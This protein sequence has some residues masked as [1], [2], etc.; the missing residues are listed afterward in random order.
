MTTILRSG[1]YVK[2]K[3]QGIGIFLEPLILYLILFLRGLNVSA[4][5][6][7]ATEP[8]PAVIPFSASRELS[9]IAAYHIPALALIWYLLFVTRSLKR[10]IPGPGIN[11]VKTVLIGFPALVLLGFL[12]FLISGF[13]PGLPAPLQLEGPRG[14]PAIAAMVL[15]CFSTGYLE[16]SYFR[17]YLFARFRQG[18]LG[19]IKG[20]CVSSVLFALCHTYEGPLGVLNAFLAGAVLYLLISRYR[21]IHG[22]AWAHGLYNVFVYVMS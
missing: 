4:F 6:P 21:A 8:V 10:G 17:F 13:I 22:L 3:E 20:M 9:R 19:P 7:P 18:G 2:T 12:L 14:I 1:P 5:L 16:E 11:D 15:S